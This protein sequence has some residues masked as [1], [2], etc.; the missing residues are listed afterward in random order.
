MGRLL[1]ERWQGLPNQLFRDVCY[2]PTMTKALLKAL[3]LLCVGVTPRLHEWSPGFI[4]V[5]F[6]E[7][8]ADGG[9]SDGTHGG[10]LVVLTCPPGVERGWRGRRT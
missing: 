5:G 9:N 7:A 1:E 10:R 2:A 3:P 8:R 6:I 4:D